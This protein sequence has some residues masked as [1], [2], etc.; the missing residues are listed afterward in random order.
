MLFGKHINR[1]YL[2]Y[3]PLL[4]LGIAALVVVDYMQLIIPELYRSVING[5]T[6]GYVTED[7][8]A[9]PFDMPYLLQRIC[10]P[11]IGVIL[12]IVVGRFLWRICFRGSAIAMETHLRA[13]MFDHCKD[14]SQEYYQTNKVGNLMT[15]FTNDLETVQDCFGWGVLMFCDALFLF[16][17]AIGK[18]YRMNATLT[19]LSL[20]PMAFLLGIGALLDHH[21]E[22]RWDKRQAAF[23]SLSDFSQESFSGIAVVKAF[24]KETVELMSFRRLNRENED[25]NVAHAKLSTLLNILVTLFVESVICVILGYGGYLVYN[26]TFNAGMLVEFIGY[27]TAIVWPIMAVSQ[28]IEMR[29][30]GNASLKRIGALLD[31]EPTVTDRAGVAQ[32]VTLTG[33]IELRHLTFRH[34]GAAYDALTDLTVSI[35]AGEHVGIIGKTGAGKTTLVDLLLRTYG[36]ADGTLFVGG[37]D[38]N[39]IPI[40]A[41]RDFCAYVP[42]DNFLFSDTIRRNIT[43]AREDATEAEVTDAAR[44]SDIHDN[45]TAFTDGYET[46]LGERGVTVSGGQKQRISI[47]RALIRD[48]GILILDDAV[49]A[50]DVGTEKIILENLRR[51]RAGKT[52]LLIAHRISTVR[53]MDKILFLDDGRLVD[54]GT[55][56][57][58]CERCEA[59]ARMVELQRLS[60]EQGTKEDTAHV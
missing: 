41:V 13:R 40:R 53:D 32:D 46:V 1:Y 44:L 5:M 52:T 57:E 29:S 58:L 14:L 35:R 28:L 19:L 20:I 27:F 24:V 39:A 51:T 34:P 22:R 54:V 6:E 10:L 18:M 36:V 23:S 49:S 8:T 56:A 12:L 38:V 25:A 48:A 30:R 55:H 33:D 7:G 47:A 60:D 31:A 9:V 59:Y 42:Q 17:L 21:L 4:I 45:I 26:G 11:L 50:V 16:I 15:L 3:L 43:F 37:H 2:R